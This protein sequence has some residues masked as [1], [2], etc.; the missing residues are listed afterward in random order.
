MSNPSRDRHAVDVAG[1]GHALPRLPY[2]FDALEPH[3]DSQTMQIHYRKHHQA[4][5][6]SLD[7][8]LENYPELRSKTAEDLCREIGSVPAEVRT[9]VR[10]SGGGHWNHCRCWAWMTPKA[11]GAPFGKAAEAINTSFGDLAAFKEQFSSA[12][13]GVCGSG[14]AWLVKD[15][16]TL[17]ITTTPNQDNPLMDGKTPILGIDVWEHA[18]YLKYQNRRADYVKAWWN[19]VNWAEVNRAL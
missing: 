16:T 2:G 19:V 10:N 12:A 4:Y 9:L 6:D 14:W 18:Y 1:P 11:G 7:G 5:I 8:A 13:M 15:G 17:F 3:I